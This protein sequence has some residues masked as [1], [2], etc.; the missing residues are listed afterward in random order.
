MQNEY[1]LQK[2]IIALSQAKNWEQARLEWDLEGVYYEDEPDTCLCGHFPINEICTLRNRKNDNR[3]TIGNVCVKRFLGLPSD[4]IFRAVKRVRRDSVKSLNEEAIE[5]AFLKGW[6]NQW[7][8]DFY[9]DI[10]RKRNLTDKQSNKKININKK[11]L[12]HSVN[13]RNIGQIVDQ[14]LIVSS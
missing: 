6:I 8:R 10:S 3:A 2:E 5:W 14:V 7:E 4:R 1:K 13:A 11:L 9:L 12:R